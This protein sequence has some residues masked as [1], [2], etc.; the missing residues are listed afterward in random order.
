VHIQQ[1]VN[2]ELNHITHPHLKFG[3]TTYDICHIYEIYP[4]LDIY[5]CLA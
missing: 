2:S 3:I 5:F 4:I 1:F